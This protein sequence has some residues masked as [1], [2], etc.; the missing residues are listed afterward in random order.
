MRRVLFLLSQEF[1]AGRDIKVTLMLVVIM[2]IAMLWI[3][4]SF[5]KVQ[6]ISLTIA[7]HLCTEKCPQ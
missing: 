7:L 5:R 1:V 6:N 4:A 3:V 2:N